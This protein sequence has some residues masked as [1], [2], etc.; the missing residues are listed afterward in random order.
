M[1]RICDKSGQVLCDEVED[2]V[3]WKDYFATLLESDKNNDAQVPECWEGPSVVD[4]AAECTVEISVE[5]VQ[6][7]IRRLKSRKAPE[8]CGI[9]GEMLKAGGDVVVQW[10]HRILGM[11]WISSTVTADW[12]KTQIVLVQ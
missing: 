7:C 10:L 1:G 3:R 4:Q 9:R 6:E 2:R 8:A 5:D 11:A 12:Q